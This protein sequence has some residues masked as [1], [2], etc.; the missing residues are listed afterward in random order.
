MSEYWLGYGFQ[1]PGNFQKELAVENWI[2]GAVFFFMGW[3][4]LSILDDIRGELR[5]LRSRLE[6]LDNNQSTESRNHSS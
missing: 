3:A 5:K 4:V 2:I 6:E 1:S